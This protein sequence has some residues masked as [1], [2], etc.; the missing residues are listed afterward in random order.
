MC[1]KQEL[2]NKMQFPLT[3][4]LPIDYNRLIEVNRAGFYGLLVK[5]EK[6]APPNELVIK[7]NYIMVTVR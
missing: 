1:S 7:Q 3:I 2:R 4:D 6:V 5:R